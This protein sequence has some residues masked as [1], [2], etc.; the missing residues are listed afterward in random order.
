MHPTL[1]GV[2]MAVTMVAWLGGLAE[3]THRPGT[4]KHK[5]VY[6]FN[7]ADDGS[8]VKKARAVLGNIQN[9]VQG[10]GGWDGIESLVLVVHGD[11]IMP[12]IEKDMDPEVRKRFDL[13]TVGGMKFG[14]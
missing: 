2:L 4:K 5:V 11:G 14:V 3:A 9:H 8:H 1:A 7:G 6:H 10:V 12:F 13:L